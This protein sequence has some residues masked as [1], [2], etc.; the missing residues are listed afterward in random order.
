MNKKID[1]GICKD[2]IK[3]YKEIIKKIEEKQD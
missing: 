1:C 3:E 2:R